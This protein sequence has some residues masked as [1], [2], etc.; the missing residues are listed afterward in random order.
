V[1]SRRDRIVDAIRV[2]TGIEGSLDFNDR[3]TFVNLLVD[4]NRKEYEDL[5]NT[6]IEKLAFARVQ[7]RDIHVRLRF[8]EMLL[9][10][11]NKTGQKRLEQAKEELEKLMQEHPREIVLQIRFAQAELWSKNYEEALKRFTALMEDSAISDNRQQ[12]DVWMGWVDSV[13]G[14]VGNIAR[15][16]ARDEEPAEKYVDAFFTA[17]R[18]KQLQ[19][20]YETVDKVRPAMPKDRITNRHLDAVKFYSQSMG[21]L[22]ESMSF[23]GQTDVCRELFERAISI[24]H[25]DRDIWQAYA[26]ALKHQKQFQKAKI[27]YDA[28]LKNQIPSELPR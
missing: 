14:A 3:I 24:N 22:G 21:R 28:L 23:I 2:Y 5:I 19:K 13:T 26:D 1:L 27:I 6:Q 7:P 25:E 17:E 9:W 10:A 4:S 12:L 18:R 20:A 11:G 15:R 8:A 16:A